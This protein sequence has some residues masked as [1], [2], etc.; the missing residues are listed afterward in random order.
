MNTVPRW[1]FIY[2][3][4]VT[5]MTFGLSSM[6]IADPGWDFVARNAAPAFVAVAVFLLA[7]NNPLGYLAVIVSRTT[8]EVG[9]VITT[10]ISGETGILI[11]SAVMLV[12][13]LAALF[14]L[15]PLVKSANQT[16]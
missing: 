8:I 14:V 3:I 16:E 7:R 9:D 15:I 11:F 1:I 4:I 5:L 6:F 2:V 12:I 10:L 13:D